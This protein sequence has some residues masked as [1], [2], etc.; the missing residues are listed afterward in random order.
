MRLMA[1]QD[2]K[3]LVLSDDG[4]PTT[5]GALFERFIAK[6]LAEHYGFDQP[7]TQSINVTSDG[8]A[9]ASFTRKSGRGTEV[10]S[11]QR[12]TRSPPAAPTSRAS[13]CWVRPA[14][15]RAARNAEGS[16]PET[17]AAEHYLHALVD[18]RQGRHRAGPVRSH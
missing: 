1:V 2:T 7:T 11:S 18:L 8:S 5:K 3:V 6:L 9:R 13:S 17:I 15:S 12:E 16:T 10:P 4:E 14:F